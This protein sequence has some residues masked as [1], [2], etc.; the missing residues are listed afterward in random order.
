VADNTTMGSVT[1]V[2]RTIDIAGVKTGVSKLDV[3]MVP[4]TELLGLAA[5]DV[6]IVPSAGLTTA[7][8]AYTAGDQLGAEMTFAVGRSTVRGAVITDALLF[9]RAKVVGAVDLYLFQTASTP[10]GDNA[11]NAWADTVIPIGIISFGT[12]VASANNSVAR[13]TDGVPLV[14]KGSASVNVFGVL[15]TRAAHTFFGAV[16][17]LVVVLGFE[18]V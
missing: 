11:P 4:T 14:V 9:D 18:P 17:D 13:P 15:V 6:L 7:T 12:P 5:P 3:A 8:T 10:A 1:D 2:L 16:T